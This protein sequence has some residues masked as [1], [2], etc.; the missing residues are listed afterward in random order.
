MRSA[1][2]GIGELRN[3]GKMEIT[4]D[5]A[6]DILEKAKKKGATDGDIIVV[7]GRSSNVLVRLSSVDKITDSQYKTLG[8]RLFF[9]K[10][11]AISSTSDFTPESLE[12]MIEDTC[13]LARVTAHDEFAGLQLPRYRLKVKET[14]LYDDSVHQLTSEEMIEMAKTAEASA[15]KYDDRITNSDGGICS[16]RFTHIVYAGTNNLSG[17]YKT[18]MFSISA[19]PIASA[20][21]LM[22][23]DYWYSSSRR[24]SQLDKPERIGETA[25][26]RTVRRLGARKIH[27]QQASVVFDPETASTLLGNLCTP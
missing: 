21:G 18:S 12:K 10:K 8:L 20:D 3:W 13:A 4:I 15:F 5:I 7:E 17:E 23:R 25:A 14:D 26:M 22:Q 1:E 2:C 19:T 9:G 24:F 6:Q 27:T 11:S 16:K